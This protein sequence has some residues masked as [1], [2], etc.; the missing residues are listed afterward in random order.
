ME[1]DLGTIENFEAIIERARKTGPRR[2]CVASA[3]DPELLQAVKQACDMGLIYPILTGKSEEIA[4]CAKSCGLR[5]YDAFQCSGPEEAA[6]A[7][8]TMVREGR[9]DILMK[10]SVNTSVFMRAVLNRE[11]GLRAGGLV[12]LLA[13]YE[14]P[15]YPKLIFATDSG[16]NP[17]P[18]LE[19]KKEI[20]KNALTAMKRIGV[21]D[22][23]VAMLT[24]NEMVDPKIT[25]TVDAAA[26]VQFADSGQCPPC[27]AEGPVAFDVAFDPAAAAHKGIDSRISG[28]VDLILFPNMETG[29]ALGKSW[30]YFN[31]AKWAGIVLGAAKPVIL[32]SRS[33]SAAVKINSIALGCLAAGEQE[34]EETR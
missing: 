28:K 18:D 8:V 23:K 10:G 5:E 29:N 14:L 9:A 6:K 19:Q 16:V 30:L 3:G 33:D 13:V 31:R 4:A 12:S 34:R 24:A 2:V 17:A 27:T 7:A 11:Q 21:E 22:P 20:L 26:L 1:R 32:G 25:S 15:G